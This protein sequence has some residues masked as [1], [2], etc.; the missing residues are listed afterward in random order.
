MPIVEMDPA[1]A[2]KLVEGYQNELDSEQRALDAFYRQFRCKQC[3][4]PVTKELLKDHA[5]NDKD[6]LVPRAC[7][8]CQICRCLFDPHT[9]IV[10]E[11]GTQG[12]VP[13]IKNK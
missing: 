4:G 13:I 6:T 3:Q 9:G 1:L 12:A 5:F 11:M 7:L 8:R 2:W 10:L